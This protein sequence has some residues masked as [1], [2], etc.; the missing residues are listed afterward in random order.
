MPN[1]TSSEKLQCA[2]YVLSEQCF[3]REK[4][5]EAVNLDGCTCKVSGILIVLIS[6]NSQTT[7]ISLISC[8]SEYLEHFSQRTNHPWPGSEAQNRWK[9]D[10]F[11]WEDCTACLHHKA[12]VISEVKK[13][14]RISSKKAVSPRAG[15]GMSTE[16]WWCADHQGNL[17]NQWF[18]K[19]MEVYSLFYK[20]HSWIFNQ[21]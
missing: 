16:Q 6:S 21:V 10:W 2:S 1:S 7:N 3:T 19:H 18:F 12:K 9:I 14:K 4:E 20:T 13:A 17:S 11:S 15:W 8:D 5:E